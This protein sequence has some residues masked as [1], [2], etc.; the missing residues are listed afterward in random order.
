ME[1]SIKCNQ[2]WIDLKKYLEIYGDF[3]LKNPLL[4]D[5]V[6]GET[7]E[8]I[9]S[10]DN[11]ERTELSVERVKLIFNEKMDERIIYEES[12]DMTDIYE[13]IFVDEGKDAIIKDAISKMVADIRKRRNYE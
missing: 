5:E 9:F 4:T 3:V 13:D 8:E 7:E 1:V 12:E 2:Q 11:S 6:I 10:M